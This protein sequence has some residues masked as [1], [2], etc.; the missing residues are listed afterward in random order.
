M[1]KKEQCRKHEKQKRTIV[2]IIQKY[3]RKWLV[4]RAY[5]KSLSATMSI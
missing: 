3:M 2:A 4:R 5:L 1:E